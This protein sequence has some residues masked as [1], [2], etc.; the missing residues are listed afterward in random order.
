MATVQPSPEPAANWVLASLPRGDY[1]QLLP[2]LEPVPLNFGEVLHNAGQPISHVYFPYSGLISLLATEHGGR[3]A[4]VAVV[5][6]EGMVGLSILLGNDVSPHRAIVQGS[7]QA[8]RIPADLFRSRARPNESLTVLLLH[9]T[10]AF[11]VQIS[12]SAMCDHLHSVQQRLCRWLLLA[13]DRI[14]SDRLPYTQKFMADIMAVRL[15]SVSQAAR[16]LQ[17]AGLIHYN[18][19]DLRILDRP[20]LERAACGCYRIIKDRFDALGSLTGPV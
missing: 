14:G 5:G 3:Q 1:E 19:G 4:E 8:V 10:D 6:N 18:R 15:A 11:L 12:Q 20:G 17:Q 16:P 13:Q 2:C 7:G 9:Y